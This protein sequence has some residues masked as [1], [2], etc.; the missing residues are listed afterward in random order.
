[1]EGQWLQFIKVNSRLV[2]R[3][4][5]STAAGG[6][7]RGPQGATEH[8]G[9]S[10]GSAAAPQEEE[11]AWTCL[12]WFLLRFLD[13]NEDCGCFGNNQPLP[14]M[15]PVSAHQHPQRKETTQKRTVS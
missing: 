2:R 13:L 14:D 9:V 11:R 6:G 1:M 4:S 15:Y 8:R 5:V 10:S 12:H 7:A 3:C